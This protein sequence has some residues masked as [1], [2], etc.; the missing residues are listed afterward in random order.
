MSILV[1]DEVLSLHDVEL[2]GTCA[3]YPQDRAVWASGHPRL[4]CRRCVIWPA[5]DEESIRRRVMLA[6]GMHLP[7]SNYRSWNRD[8][9][10]Q[11]G[12]TR[13]RFDQ[14]AKSSFRI[15]TASSRLGTPG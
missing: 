10:I 2:T 11:A 12:S 4:S 7:M 3:G 6:V 5:I 8:C 9:A 15:S 13:K 1:L 14:H